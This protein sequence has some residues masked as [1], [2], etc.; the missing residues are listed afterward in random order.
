MR[1]T[2]RRT[3]DTVLNIVRND[4][5]A[6][7]NAVTSCDRHFGR[8]LAI[9]MNLQ[10]IQCASA[11][12]QS[13]TSLPSGAPA[14]LLTFGA[15]L[16]DRRKVQEEKLRKEEEKQKRKVNSPAEKLKTRTK[17]SVPHVISE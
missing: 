1:Q 6:F 17:K 15:M 10:S 9:M 16:G 5:G 8:K 4:K 14:E 7:K 12:P 3:A 13:N 2:D 11:P